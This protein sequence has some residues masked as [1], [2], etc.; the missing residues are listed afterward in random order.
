MGRDR[1]GWMSQTPLLGQSVVR[2]SVR[3]HMAILTGLPLGRIAVRTRQPL[4]IG[5]V[6][7]RSPEGEIVARRAEGALPAQGKIG[8]RIVDVR[9]GSEENVV[10]I[11]R[12]QDAQGEHSRTICVDLVG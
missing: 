8:V 10:A 12:S 2:V 1:L 11:G 9:V 6:D 3:R 5:G 4:G 7:R